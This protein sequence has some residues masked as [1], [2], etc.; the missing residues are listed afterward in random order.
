MEA[1][2]NEIAKRYAK[3]GK[4]L[5]EKSMELINGKHLPTDQELEKIKVNLLP[6]E[7]AKMK[8]SLTSEPIAEYWFKVFTNCS[9]LSQ[10]IFDPDHPILKHIIQIDH[11][12]EE[13]SE[14]FVLKFHFSPNE[15]FENNALTARFIMLSE[16]E[17]DKIEGTDIKW[18]EGKDVTKKT[19]TKKQKNK[20]TG[21]PRTITKTVD[22]DSFFNLFKSIEG[23]GAGG[24]GGDEED[25]DDV[26]LEKLDVHFDMARTIIEDILEYHLEFYLGVR[27]DE[28]GGD[29][30]EDDDLDDDLDDSGEDEAPP[31]KG[32]G[33]KK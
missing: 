24:N 22:A 8:E 29:F 12:T 2:M 11:I 21:K 31:K 14:N 16:N 30:N 7:L 33:K 19:I 6:E 3:L 9:Q 25:E 1:E 4:P 28:D 13:G 5:T 23:K 26:T 27:D 10:D 18:K 20:K 17:V 32:K 15:Y